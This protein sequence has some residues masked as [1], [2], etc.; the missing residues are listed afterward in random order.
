MTGPAAAPAYE[1]Y[2][3]TLPGGR[4]VLSP[5]ANQGVALWQDVMDN[6]IYAQAVAGLSAGDVVFDVGAN[7]GF[8]AYF[9]TDLVPGLRVYSFEPAEACYACLKVNAARQQ[10]DITAIQAAVGSKP[11][12][13]ELTYYPK[14]PAQSSLYPDSDEDRRNS[15]A[16]LVNSGIRADVADAFLATMHQGHSYP[17]E[18]TTVAAA[19]DEY[20]VDEIALLKIDVERAEQ[21]VLDGIGEAGWSRVRRVAAEIHDTDGRLDSITRQLSEG[22]FKVEVGQERLLA[23]TNVRMLLAARDR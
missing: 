8:A 19:V 14:S 6:D 17:V 5:E 13:A 11:G 4:K 15:T 2:E 20:G 23:G 21:D 9:F 12:T 18:V 16:Y 7:I 22:G 3:I 1:T 10:A